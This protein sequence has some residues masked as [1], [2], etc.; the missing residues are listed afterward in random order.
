MTGVIRGLLLLL[1]IVA[2]TRAGSVRYVT[3]PTTSE[4]VE[5]PLGDDGQPPDGVNLFGFDPTPWKEVGNPT[6]VS[7]SA[8]A[9]TDVTA[10]VGLPTELANSA[11]FVDFDQDGW[12]DV[13]GVGDRG[14]ALYR[15]TG[16]KFINV[17][18]TVGG[19]ALAHLPDAATLLFGDVD[20][21]G[22]LD[23]YAATRTGPGLLFLA[24]GNYRLVPSEGA[25]P[26]RTDPGGVNFVDVDRD[27]NIDLYVTGAR[28]NAGV[29]SAFPPGEQ[30]GPSALF[31]NNGDGTFSDVTALWGAEAGSR[32]E[33]FGAVFADF[34]QDGDPDALVV[35]D[36]QP[37]HFYLNHGDHFEDRT[38]TAVGGQ[39]TTLM[40]LAVGD[41]DGDGLLDMYGTQFG[42]DYLYRGLGKATF[43]NVW[44]AV[45]DG[46]DT[47]DMPLGWGCAFADIDNDGDQDIVVASSYD[48]KDLSN[49]NASPREGG[50]QLFENLG[51]GRFRDA[52]E[53]SRLALPVNAYSLSVGDVDRDGD[54]DVLVSSDRISDPLVT[55]LPDGVLRMGM[56]LLRNDSGRA[57]TN[58]FLELQLSMPTNRQAIGATVEVVAGAV[59]TSRVVTAGESYRSQLPYV[60]HFG[61]GA[62]PVADLVTV[63]WPDGA[64][65]RV[66]ALKA[67]YHR[68]TPF[69]G[70]CCGGIDCPGVA[71]A[72]PTLPEREPLSVTRR[73]P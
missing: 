70:D 39:S 56:R 1:P 36:L 41:Y 73:R 6:H 2:C 52:S 9:F 27:G 49:P 34:D 68:L 42:P 54:L 37:D 33:S 20:N 63:R 13:A 72:C 28:R 24:Q 46:N 23:L 31:R 66:H 69:T 43:K 45:L 29:G 64:V 32:S 17:T 40:G 12:V 7:F 35:R 44:P 47:T 18:F 51:T 5:G 10:A 8:L 38:E 58:R 67:G 3:V 50:M 48:Q 15:N 4:D 55:P 71:T 57:A 26:A 61:L 53:E 62:S 21:D 14:I 59:R 25:V 16:V 30:G 11:L 22:D 19:V 65:Q 60:L